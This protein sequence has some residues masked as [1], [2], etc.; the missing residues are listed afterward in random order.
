MITITERAKE[1]LKD[2]LVAAEA[3]PD[4]G[5][6]LLPTSEDVFE[7][8]LDTEM[9]GDLVVEYEGYKVLAEAR[10]HETRGF[11]Q[12]VRVAARRKYTSEEKVRIVLEGFRR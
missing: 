7:L 5:L 3:E 11:M 9:S 4:E 2:V 12:Q 8:M 10:T 1:E 6:R